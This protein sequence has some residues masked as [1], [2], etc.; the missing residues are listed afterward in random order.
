MHHATTLDLTLPVSQQLAGHFAHAPTPYHTVEYLAQLAS[1]A[2]FVEY[3]ETDQ[4]L[5][6]PGE[7]VII[8]RDGSIILAVL[9]TKPLAQT[10]IRL[11]GAHTDSPTYKIRPNPMHQAG[12]MQLLNVEPYGGIL[13]ESWFDRDLTV[14]GRVVLKDGHIELVHLDYPCAR[15]A[16]LAIHLTDREQKATA[17]NPHTKARPIWGMADDPS[18]FEVISEQLGVPSEEIL[19]HDLVLVPTE[20]PVIGGAGKR[21]FFSARQDNLLGTFTAM[22]ALF[23]A[24]NDDENTP[25]ARAVVCNDFEEIGSST[26]TG[27]AGPFLQETLARLVHAQGGSAEDVYRATAQS[28]LV[29][30][31]VA[32]GWHPNYA[33]RYDEREY[34]ILGGGPCL[35]V[36]ANQSYATTGITAAWAHQAGAQAGVPV[37]T[38]TSRADQRCGSTIGPITATRLGIATVDMGQPIIGM[39]SIRELSHLDDADTTTAFLT[40]CLNTP[41][42]PFI[43]SH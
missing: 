4:W 36:N 17:F 11:I 38:F 40:A 30:L 7:K 32:H 15:I 13:H 43:V 21:F 2:G 12:Q 19:T 23:N 14:A 27:A 37:Q 16:H 1:L 39:H 10:G 24:L 6:E 29:S 42:L 33:D 35:K 18:L 26:N 3:D 28:G 9:G 8:R 34:P 25:Y 5:V 41:V 31:D 20:A 22:H